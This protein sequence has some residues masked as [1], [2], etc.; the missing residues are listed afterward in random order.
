MNVRRAEPRKWLEPSDECPGLLDPAAGPLQALE[1]V[2]FER[3]KTQLVVPTALG[4]RL[5]PK[6]DLE[7]QAATW[8]GMTRE[9]R[10][11]SVDSL[12]R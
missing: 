1:G 7:A 8:V 11:Q 2:G 12:P 3:G 4:K 10:V 9:L 6:S 5:E